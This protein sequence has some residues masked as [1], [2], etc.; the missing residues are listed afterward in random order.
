LKN[1]YKTLTGVEYK[2]PAAGSAQKENKKPAAAASAA[3]GGQAEKLLEKI[4]QQGNTVRD[5]KQ[6]KSTPP[7]SQRLETKS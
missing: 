6:N 3:T 5:L 7:V 1:Q 2:P 4:T